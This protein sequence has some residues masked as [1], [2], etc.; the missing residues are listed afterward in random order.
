LQL[1]KRNAFYDQL[2]FVVGNAV[3]NKIKAKLISS[4]SELGASVADDKTTID[5]LTKHRKKEWH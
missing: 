3:G 1:V 4:I 5:R 2:V